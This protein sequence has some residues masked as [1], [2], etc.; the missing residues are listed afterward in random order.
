MQ[1]SEPKLKLKLKIKMNMNAEL[2]AKDDF[3]VKINDQ[4][5]HKYNVLDLFCGCGGLSYGFHK[6]NNYNI[7]VANDIWSDAIDTYKHNWKTTPTILGDICDPAIKTDIISRFTG[8]K[9]NIIIGG[10]PC[11]AYSM[12]GKRDP[13]DPRAQLF[14][15]YL[16]MVKTLNPD[17]CVMENVKGML[18]AKYLN[19]SQKVI[20]K[21]VQEFNQCGYTIKY[22]LLDSSQYGVPQRRERIIILATK[23]NIDPHLE[24]NFP[25]ITHPIPITVRDAI[26]DLIEMP[27][28]TNFSHIF[29]KHSDEIVEKIRLTTIGASMNPKYKEAF[30][31]CNPDSPSLTVKENH[32]GV[33]L[34]YEKNRVMTPRELA[35]LQSFPDNYIFKSSK[36]S[37]LKQIGNAVPVLL[38]C[39]LADSIIDQLSRSD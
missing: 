1:N 9:C 17:I 7:V 16:S 36:S 6:N 10:P 13:D 4:A 2:I 25:P 34:H 30:Y 15:E 5:I 22:K 28:N 14:K 21:I 3:D 18:S 39:A 37:I 24:I 38:G 19:T 8:I 23:N 33:F 32:G 11:Q 26:S 27:E 20:D 31:K 12:A 29:S 35:R